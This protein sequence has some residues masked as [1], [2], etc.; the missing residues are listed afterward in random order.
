MPVP[1]AA[2]L[3]GVLLGLGFTTFILTFAVWALAGVVRR[4]GRPDARA[5]WSASRFGVGRTLPGRRSSR[6]FGGGAAHAAMA[7]QP[8]ILRW[9]RLA[10]AAALAVVRRRAVRR[11][12]PGAGDRR[13]RRLLRPERGRRRRSRS[14]ARAAWASYAARPACRRC[15]AATRRSAAAGRPGSP[16][17]TWS[18]PGWARS[19]RPAPTASRCPARYV[20]WR[21]GQELVGAALTDLAPRQLVIGAVGRP[22]LSGNLLVFDVDG[23]IE[24]FDL[25]TGVRTMLRRE[26]RAQLRGP[27]VLGG[28][29][30]YVRATYT[31][32]QVRRRPPAPAARRP[33]TRRSTAPT[34]P[35][36]AT[37]ATSRAASPPR[38]TST[39]RCGSRPPAGVPGHADDDRGRARRR[40]RHAGAQARRA[41]APAA[42]VLRRR[43]LAEA[44][45]ATSQSS[46]TGRSARASSTTASASASAL[47][48]IRA[49]RHRGHAHLVHPRAARCPAAC[50]RSP[51]CAP[52]ATAGR[53]PRPRDRRQPAAVLVVGAEAALAGLEVVPDAGRARASAARPARGCR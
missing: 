17:A 6:P 26:A 37:R 27:S 19:P 34:R 43:S 31:R 49:R 11:A 8:R 13:R 23:R 44:G 21:Q 24:S 12:R 9:L 15:P 20:A 7:E 32:Q 4:A 18:S 14:T 3:Y 45:A 28:E 33:A 47:T 46:S 53:G 2:G 1:L 51:P 25:V 29:L 42:T 22:A 41:T 36:A 35:P 48:A 16:T 10:D 39:S 40:V 5:C 38:A 52:A 50:R 30:A